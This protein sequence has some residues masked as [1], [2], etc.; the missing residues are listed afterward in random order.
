[1][2]IAGDSTMPTYDGTTTMT[3]NASN[4]MIK[5]S[6]LV[7]ATAV[8]FTIS[9]S[10]TESTTGTVTV[11]VQA[12]TGGTFSFTTDGRNQS[13]DDTRE[14]TYTSNVESETVAFTPDG[15]SNTQ[16]DTLA[17]DRILPT[18]S[19]DYST[20]ELTTGVVIATL[21]PNQSGIEVTNNS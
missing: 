11:T 9:Y 20:T 15:D 6:P 4:G 8:D 12:L 18:A 19:V 14:K 1:M 5:I 10:T 7:V 2:T 17:I 16:Y 21:V 3:G 13:N